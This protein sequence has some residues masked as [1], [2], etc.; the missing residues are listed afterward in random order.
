[1]WKIIPFGGSVSSVSSSFRRFPV[2]PAT[3]KHMIVNDEAHPSEPNR[4]E[5]NGMRAKSH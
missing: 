4:T 3:R 2:P 1:M 5:P